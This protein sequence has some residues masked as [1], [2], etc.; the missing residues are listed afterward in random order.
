MST[1]TGKPWREVDLFQFMPTWPKDMDRGKRYIIFYRRT[2]DH[3]QTMMEE[4]LLMPLDGPVTLVE[5]P[6]SPTVMTM[7]GAPPLPLTV[8]TFEQ[9]Q[10]PLGTN[11]LIETPLVIAI[12]DGVVTCAQEGAH[13]KCLGLE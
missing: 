12:K 8:V 7:E 10:L 2:C 11:W 13:K 4:D 1:W 9:L 6:E 5:V 3:C